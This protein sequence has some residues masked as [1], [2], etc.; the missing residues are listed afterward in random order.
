M[1]W[2]LQGK[3]RKD[4]TAVAKLSREILAIQGTEIKQKQKNGSMKD[5]GLAIP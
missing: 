3:Y 1:K 5:S 2:H 4:E